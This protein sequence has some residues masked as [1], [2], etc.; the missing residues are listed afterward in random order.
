[1]DL[2]KIDLKNIHKIVGEMVDGIEQ[3]EMEGK[4]P[5]EF[6]QE[7]G[8]SNWMEYAAWSRHTGG[9]YQ[10]ME[11][12]LKKKWKEQDP[13]EF[14]RQ[15]KIQNDQRTREHSY[16]GIL[17]EEKTKKKGKRRYKPVHKSEFSAEELE[18]IYDERGVLG[19]P[20]E[21]KWSK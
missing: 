18:V 12:A 2:N 9:D 21:Y 19:E 20:V 3:L 6:A 10:M 11:Y 17:D 7:R 16:I 14:A 8:F 15:K 5:D 4:T 1:M 13:E